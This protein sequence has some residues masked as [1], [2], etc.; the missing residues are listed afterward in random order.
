[1]HK[2]FF[3]SAFRQV[4]RFFAQN[5][6]YLLSS[7]LVR[8]MGCI[9][10]RWTLGAKLGCPDIA[11]GPRCHLRGLAYMH[12]GKNFHAAE[13]LWMEAITAYPGQAFSPSI[14]IGNNVFIS[15]WSHIAATCLVKIGDG[16]LI[17]SKVLITD[18][19]HGDYAETTKQDIFVSPAQRR[20]TSN[21][22]TIIGNNVWL[23]DG[24]IVMPGVK[25]GDSSVIGANSVV[26][27]DV[28]S[29]TVAA[30]VPAVA[31]KR[32][33]LTTQEWRKL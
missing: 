3:I 23:G 9:F 32:F 25:I 13:G 33:D 4:S 18:H 1:M 14:V 27:H 21:L 17:G 24:V 11:F 30:G 19:Q 2:T 6:L 29:F 16:V 26:T 15:R 10:R 31:L 12:I 8:R 5:G 28:P 7:E 20:L 22:E